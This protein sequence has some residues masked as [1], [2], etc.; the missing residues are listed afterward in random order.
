MLEELVITAEA[1]EA[2]LSSENIDDAIELAGEAAALAGEAAA[3]HK[4][5]CK[6]LRAALA[7][8]RHDASHGGLP[9]SRDT[10]AARVAALEKALELAQR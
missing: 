9:P 4:K 5:L 2:I 6:S 1:A 3:R 8:C 7:W 10:L